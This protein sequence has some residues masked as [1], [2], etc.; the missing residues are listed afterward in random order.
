MCEYCGIDEEKCNVL[1]YGLK[2][3]GIPDQATKDLI[4]D[5]HNDYRRKVAK[6]EETK[7]C[8]MSSFRF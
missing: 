2:A 4:L 1:G 6:G 3:R 5:M 8:L 7:V